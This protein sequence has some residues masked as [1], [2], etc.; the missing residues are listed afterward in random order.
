[1]TVKL[2]LE[3]AFSSDGMRFCFADFDCV[4]FEKPFRAATRLCAVATG[5]AMLRLKGSCRWLIGGLDPVKKRG[6]WADAHEW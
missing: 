3:N 4:T 2:T 1:M 6:T 5:C